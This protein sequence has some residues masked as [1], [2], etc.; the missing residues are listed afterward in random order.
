M[1][2]QENFDSPDWSPGEVEYLRYNYP[3]IGPSA[4]RAFMQNRSLNAL[5]KK[6]KKL[7]LHYSPKN[8]TPQENEAF[9]GAWRHASFRE[10]QAAFPGKTVIAFR[11][12]AAR[13][14][15]GERLQDMVSEAEGCRIL[16]VYSPEFRKIVGAYPV[17]RLSAS[18]LRRIRIWKYDKDQLIAAAKEYFALELLTEASQRTGTHCGVLRSACK[19]MQAPKIGAVYR[20]RP[21]DWD[22]LLQVWKE[23][24]KNQSVRAAKTRWAKSQGS[25]LPAT[26]TVPTCASLGI[27]SALSSNSYF[28]RTTLEAEA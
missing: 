12:K 14:K 7:G 6:A 4:C 26:C 13:L 9:A 23:Y 1:P 15:L 20:M 24:T 16:G 2:V 19:A 21:C 22:R 5:R 3:R 8:W 27:G 18:H 10:L 17:H 11:R 25:V 28:K